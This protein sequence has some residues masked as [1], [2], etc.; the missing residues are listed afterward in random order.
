MASSADC[1]D[2]SAVDSADG[3]VL[4]FRPGGKATKLNLT[5]DKS[6]ANQRSNDPSF[7]LYLFLS[8]HPTSQRSLKIG[9]PARD[10][11][12]IHPLNTHRLLCSQDTV[13]RTAN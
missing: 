11:W 4:F 8:Y 13:S 10:R 9:L 5:Q 12:S 6:L 7:L 1:S 2:C 3:E